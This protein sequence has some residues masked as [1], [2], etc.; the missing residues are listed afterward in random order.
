[1]QE[2]LINFVMYIIYIP[3]V[4]IIH[5]LGHALFVVLFGKEVREIQLGFGEDL[6]R[7]KKF[8]VKRSMGWSVGYCSWENIDSLAWYKKLLIFLGG[9]ILNLLTATLVWIFG[10]VQYADWYRAFIVVSYFIAVINLFPFKSNIT[11]IDSDGL[12]CIKLLNSMK[13]GN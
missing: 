5:E 2:Q 8:V 1:M 12:Q 13:Q 9:I 3:I 7:I 10:D 11:K 6:F 4:I